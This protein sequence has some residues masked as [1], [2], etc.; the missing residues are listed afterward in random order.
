MCKTH[1]VKKTYILRRQK[2]SQNCSIIHQN[3][4]GG[5]IFLIH[6]FYHLYLRMRLSGGRASLLLLCALHRRPHCAHPAGDSGT[7]QKPQWRER[8]GGRK[9]DSGSMIHVEVKLYGKLSRFFMPR[10]FQ[11]ASASGN[12]KKRKQLRGPIE[13]RGSVRATLRNPLS[14]HPFLLPFQNHLWPQ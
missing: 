9:R 4:S 11:S 10:N 6:S 7:T 1:F 5:P 12:L 14:S 8:E 13:A 2:K 3:W